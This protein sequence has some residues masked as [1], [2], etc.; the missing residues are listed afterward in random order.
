M[1]W[2]AKVLVEVVM[3]PLTYV[4]VRFLKDTEHVDH[5]DYG[6]RFCFARSKFTAMRRKVIAHKNMPPETS[7]RCPFTQ[8][9]SGNSRAAIAPPISSGTPTRPSAVCEAIM[10]LS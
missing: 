2:A 7:I 6:N 8:R 10:A 5:Y 9:F 1:G 4:V 3:L